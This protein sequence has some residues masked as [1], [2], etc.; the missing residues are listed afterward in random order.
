MDHNVLMVIFGID[1]DGRIVCRLSIVID[2]PL[3][4]EAFGSWIIEEMML[5]WIIREFI[6]ETMSID[7]V[8]AVE[9]LS[10]GTL[11][12]RKA[13][14]KKSIHKKQNTEVHDARYCTKT[15][16]GRVMLKL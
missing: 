16:I 11:G 14:S 1:P 13:Y 9:T 5:I 8:C 2:Q 6:V 12:L 4:V 15:K 10:T 3:T 7:L